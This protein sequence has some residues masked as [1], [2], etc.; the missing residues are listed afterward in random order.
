ML[1]LNFRMMPP[2]AQ[3][4]RSAGAH[5]GKFAPDIK[6]V[7]LI[8]KATIILVLICTLEGWVDFV[9]KCALSYI[10]H[11][12]FA[13]EVSLVTTPAYSKVESIFKEVY[14][15]KNKIIK[16]KFK[17]LF[18]NSPLKLNSFHYF[19]FVCQYVWSCH[20]LYFLESINWLKGLQCYPN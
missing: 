15:E 14:K 2:R 10:H 20:E 7:K 13:D 19:L 4:P 11:C 12:H 1:R 8:F 3:H 9:R 5:R 16:I 18:S 6:K 17:R